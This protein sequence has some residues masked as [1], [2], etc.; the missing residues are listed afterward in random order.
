MLLLLHE[1]VDF[2]LHLQVQLLEVGNKED[3]VMIAGRLGQ[4]CV[5]WLHI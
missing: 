5:A 3:L 2:I 1:L 4:L